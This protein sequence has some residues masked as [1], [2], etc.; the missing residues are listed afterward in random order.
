MPVV[1]NDSGEPCHDQFPEPCTQAWRWNLDRAV[2]ANEVETMYFHDKEYNHY[3]SVANT[4]KARQ[5]VS[6]G[7]VKEIQYGWASQITD[8]KVPAKVELSHVN[9]CIERVQEND[10]LRDTPAACPTFDDKPTSYP[11]VPVDLM[12]DGTSADYECAGKTYYPTFFS[13]DMLWDIK[14]YVSD[15][16]GTGWDLVQQ[17]Q[18]K[19]GMPNPDGTIGKTLWLDYPCDINNL[20]SQATNTK[21]GAVTLV[22]RVG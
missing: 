5:Y 7:Y 16:D 14:T 22:D 6:S 21:D 2:D 10:P 15:Q 12:C 13:T 20:P 19:Y 8:G 9:R 3:R 18:N 1:G 4:D 11:D 17:Y